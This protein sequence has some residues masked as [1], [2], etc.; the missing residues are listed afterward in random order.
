M[1]RPVRRGPVA[2]I[3]LFTAAVMAG[4]CAPYPQR[5]RQEP[6][7]RQGERVPPAEGAA[8][9]GDARAE[10]AKWQ[11]ALDSITLLATRDCAP[12]LCA[13]IARNE[14]LVG[15]TER[16]VY[17]ATR[18][19]PAA[20]SVRRVEGDAV[21]VPAQRTAPPRDRLGELLMVQVANGTA[22]VV[23]RRG[24]QGLM[25]ASRPEDQSAAAQARVAA[26]A[27]VR[28]GDDLVA[29]NDLAGALNRYDR[30]SVLD[31]MAP[32]PQ[33]KAARLLDL[34]LRPLE[35][36]MRYQRFLLSL[37]I[38]RIRAQGEASARMAE[39]IA[40]AQQRI[41]VLEKQVR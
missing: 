37:D 39:A 24:P 17:A 6:V 7:V 29:A 33:F 4:A 10:Q 11:A 38:E 15:M 27:L 20:W 25:V 35:A 9:A 13:A 40:L 12:D 41:V 21:M 31:P 22:A 30:A 32:D 8:A 36:L 26:E 2:V 23:S 28:E 16:Q 3:A 14:L 34:Q 19:L 5:V 18:S 1:T